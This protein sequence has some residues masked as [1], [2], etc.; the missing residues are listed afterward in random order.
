MVIII[1]AFVVDVGPV[2]VGAQHGFLAIVI[3]GQHIHHHDVR[4]GIVVYVHHITTHGGVH[5]MLEQ[6]AC[7]VS[8]GAVAV[9]H[10][11][12]FIGHKI[13]GHVYIFPAIFV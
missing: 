10:I 1:V 11:D 4:A 2:V 12:H 13:V 7:L 3:F 8:K 9:V 5:S 6:L